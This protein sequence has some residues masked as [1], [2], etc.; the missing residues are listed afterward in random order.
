[1][2]GINPNGAEMQGIKS[3]KL[4]NGQSVAYVTDFF[5]YTSARI[6]LA[7][8][9][10][11]GSNIIIQADSDF[12]LESLNYYADINGAAVTY[13]S[14]V[15]PNVTLI[16]TDTGSGRQLMNGAV[17]VPAICGNGMQPYRLREPKLFKANSTIQLQITSFEAANTDYIQ[18]AL[19]GQKIFY[20]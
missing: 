1:M 2:S 6:A 16:I 13:N 5:V 10:N 9:A 19:I 8:A 12:F 7:P 14:L 20:L 17:P 18:F 15:I 3:F 4:A 11:V